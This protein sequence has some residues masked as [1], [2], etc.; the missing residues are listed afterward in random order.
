MEKFLWILK[1]WLEFKMFLMRRINLMH[2]DQLIYV[3]FEFTLQLCS[4]TCCL[5]QSATS[6]ITKFTFTQIRRLT[7]Y[8]KSFNDRPQPKV[9]LNGWLL[10]PKFLK[11]VFEFNFQFVGCYQFYKL[12]KST[13]GSIFS[14]GFGFIVYIKI[15]G[16]HDR[17]T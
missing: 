13:R 12:F 16:P 17:T 3:R 11:A 4:V 14:V 2:F 9:Q 10:K 15:H 8:Q 5:F 6:Y 1:E 7:R